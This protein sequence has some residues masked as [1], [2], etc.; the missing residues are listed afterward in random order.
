MATRARPRSR[1]QIAGACLSQMGGVRK[2]RMNRRS[3]LGRGAIASTDLI[4]G[5]ATLEV[6]IQHG[7]GH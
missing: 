6:P 2:S 1:Q 7:W 4:E 3:H 5:S